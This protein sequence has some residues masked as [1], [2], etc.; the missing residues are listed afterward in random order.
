MYQLIEMEGKSFE[1]KMKKFF[2]N[3][4][5][6]DIHDLLCTIEKL[7]ANF[8][9]YFN[10]DNARMSSSITEKYGALLEKEVLPE[11]GESIDN[12]L[13]E[14]S[15]Y[16]QGIMKW[17]HPGAMIN[18]NP[19]VTIQS[20]ATAGYA[21]LYNCN[22][23]Q[24]MSCGYLLT[25]E[26]AVIKMICQLAGID[27]IN[28]GGI[29]TFGGKSTNLHAL[30]H[31][32]QRACPKAINDGVQANIYTFSS[33]QGHPCHSEVCGWLGIGKNKCIKIQVDDKGAI[34]LE[35]LE[36]AIRNCITN[37]DKVALIT[38]NGGTT[39]Q[40]TIDPIKQIVELRDKIVYEY[41]LDYKP[42]VHVD[43]VIGW[44]FLFFESYDFESNPYGL[45]DAAVKKIKRQL[46]KIKEIRY[47]DSFGVDFH[48]M[49]FCS[50]QSSLY[51]CK[52]KSELYAQENL[53][54]IPYE[55]LEYGNYSPFQYTLELSRSLNGPIEAYTNLKLLGIK[56]YQELICNLYNT[57][58]TIK[59]KLSL[60]SRFEV[61][62]DN[63]SDG[64]VTLFIV[65]EKGEK[66]SF[67]EFGSLEKE[68]IKEIGLFIHSFYLY[69]FEQQ[70][71]GRCWFALDY[72]SG[73]HTLSNGQ[74]IGVLKV[75]QMSPYFTDERAIELVND[76][77]AF[78]EEFDG[79]KDTFEIKE[80]PHKP[81]PF[82]F[83]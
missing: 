28:A 18:I 34:N 72:S 31:G 32:I 69:L 67:F 52:D 33:T 26:L 1:V 8:S 13:K 56:G 77:F 43:S 63:D 66:H 15:F 81:R 62:N 57:A 40:M 53:S 59:E 44:A 7:H 54:P 74:K 16:S 14:L 60:N 20:V 3:P 21:S 36:I 46:N 10:F 47:A 70:K 73:Y 5:T 35:K 83:R 82:V 37:G 50:Y 4:E 25:T 9:Q 19:P 61:I 68:K 45:K 76:L 48:K 11:E 80:V 71:K 12:I 75:Y 78:L 65:K 22:G 27:A 51:I 17:N 64:F 55:E 38:A 29:F 6:M 79:V 49:G 23:A 30:K 2:L 42:R 24:D 58:E 39:I 41:G